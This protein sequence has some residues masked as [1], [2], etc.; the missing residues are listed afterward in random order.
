MLL[1]L[2]LLLLWGLVL[3]REIALA[4]EFVG[5]RVLGVLRLRRDWARRG[6]WWW[7]FEGEM[8][9][10]VRRV[11]DNEAIGDERE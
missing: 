9:W 6:E 7:S 3:C 2:L 5:F 11:K 1:L 10:A 8:N 4:V